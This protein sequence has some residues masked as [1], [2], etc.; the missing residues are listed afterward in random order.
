MTLQLDPA[1]QNLLFREARTANAFTDEPVTE[2]QIQDVYDLV[3][4]APTAYNQQ[5][6]RIVL[7]RSP[8]PASAWCA[9]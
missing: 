1:A 3:K 9:T 7:V 2:E 4:Y 5:P 8:R 6:L